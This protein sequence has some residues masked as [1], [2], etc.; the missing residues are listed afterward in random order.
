M[1]I[2]NKK[3][4]ILFLLITL[5]FTLGGC[6]GI[7]QHEEMRSQS[8]LSTSTTLQQDHDTTQPNNNHVMK[9]DNLS[10]TA[11]QGQDGYSWGGYGKEGFYYMRNSARDDGTCNIMYADYASQQSVYL[12]AQANCPHDNESCTSYIVPPEGGVLV[13]VVGDKLVLFFQNPAHI[14]AENEFAP[15]VE[16]AEL[17]GSNRKLLF[18][19]DANQ[20]V[21]KPMISDGRCVYMRVTTQLDAQTRRAELVQLDTQTG[22]TQT[23]REMDVDHNERL[24]GAYDGEF[25]IYRY[26]EPLDTGL[27]EVQLITWNPISEQENLVLSWKMSDPYPV[28]G[29][30]SLAYEGN[31]GFFHILDLKTRED[32]VLSQYTLPNEEDSTKDNVNVSPLFTDNGNLLIC[33]TKET[34]RTY[35]VLNTDGEKRVFTLLYDVDGDKEI[36]KPIAEIE[37]QSSY[38]ICAG[39]ANGLEKV[40][41]DDGTSLVFDVPNTIYALIAKDDYWK[42]IDSKNVLS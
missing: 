9:E 33:E 35:Y 16:T 11:L 7:Q 14:S 18:Q 38:L 37:G 23:I 28:L 26:K 42:C 29:K 32:K 19:F 25:L 39:Y 36:C 2:M 4:I 10:F 12:C 31:D 20:M 6:L 30:D 34:E 13:E 21:E 17:D 5:S 3:F 8:S 22:D 40:L 27:D 41:V 15:Y 24:W 1:F